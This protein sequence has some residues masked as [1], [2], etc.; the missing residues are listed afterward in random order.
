MRLWQPLW[1]RLFSAVFAARAK[2]G[3]CHCQKRT[4][5]AGTAASHPLMALTIQCAVDCNRNALGGSNIK[6][7]LDRLIKLTSASGVASAWLPTA[8]M[9][10]SL[11]KSLQA[12]A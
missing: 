1:L 7:S 12:A 3:K 11:T 8:F 10:I 6:A 5:E 4:A 2:C 9:G